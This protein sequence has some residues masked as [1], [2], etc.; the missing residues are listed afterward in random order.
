MNVADSEKSKNY[1]EGIF[2][3]TKEAIVVIGFDS[4]IIMSNNSASILW[5]YSC[6]EMNGLDASILI[7]SDTFQKWLEELN[8]YNQHN[9]LKRLF[10]SEK[11]VI[12]FTKYGYKNPALINC[13]PLIDSNKVV[14]GGMF[15]ATD[16]AERRY[17]EKAFWE[18]EEKL[19]YLTSF[20]ID[21][22]LM[23]DHKGKISFWNKAATSIFG[24][25]EEE[26]FGKDL[27]KLLAP[28]KYHSRFR[29]AFTLFLK[30]GKGDAVNKTLELSALRK[31][32]EEFPIELSL[33]AIRINNKWNAIAIIRD[34]SER[35]QA[36]QKIIESEAYYRTLIETSPDAIIT[37][38]IE[39]TIKFASKKAFELLG[40]P[41][42]EFVIDTSILQWI[43]PEFHKKALERIAGIYNGTYQPKINEYKLLKYNGSPIICEI[44]S[45]PFLNSEGNISGLLIVI[46]DISERKK[47]IMNSLKPKRKLKRATN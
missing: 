28:S 4:K 2:H 46:H 39:G 31:S 9:D 40:I 1:F 36:E 7:E 15:T 29:N 42:T 33:S 11:E 13:S 16:L 38:D 45:S 21:G 43:D 5:S 44:S 6:E 14:Y 35:K 37:A 12:A 3:S 26:I 20:A 18:N 22:I 27:H 47:L 25:A 10:L 23:M 34:I 8:Q 19:R 32:G 24:Y 30:T 41:G 17:L